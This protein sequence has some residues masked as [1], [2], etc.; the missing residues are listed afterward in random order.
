MPAYTSDFGGSTVIVTGAT[1]G[2]RREIAL[3]FAE[4]GRRSSTPTS[5]ED[6]KMAET[7]THE[8]IRQRGGT[9]DFVRTDVSNADGSA[10]W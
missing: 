8:T 1:S 4:E 2:I 9:A 10:R 5:R 3:R 7:P 6:P